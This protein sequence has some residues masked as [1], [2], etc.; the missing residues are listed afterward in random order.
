MTDILNLDGGQPELSLRENARAIL[1]AVLEAFYAHPSNT[2]PETLHQLRIAAKRL[3][4]SLEFFEICYGKRLARSLDLMASLQELLGHVHDCDVM[5]EYL[6]RR[7]DKLAAR[8]ATPEL[9]S[10]LNLLIAD[11]QLKRKQLAAEF[12]TL[13]RR[14]FN[15]GFKTRLLKLLARP[16]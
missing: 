4:Y 13:W 6:N 12:V 11:F 3:R 16:A 7:Y 14:K 8:R 5:I 15:R 10:G 2:D 1:P 9:L